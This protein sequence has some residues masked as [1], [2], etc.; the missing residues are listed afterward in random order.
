[1]TARSGAR[2]MI[3]ALLLAAAAAAQAAPPAG[4]YDAQLCVTVADQAASC[5]P[6]QARLACS[7]LRLQVSDIVYRLQ[8]HSSQLDVTLMHGTMQI[9]GF[10]APYDWA[11]STLRFVDAEKSARYE[12]QIGARQSASK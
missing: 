6:V 7:A 1:M 11:G 3:I 12:V 2:R 10:S 5:G 4:D 9:D 8:L